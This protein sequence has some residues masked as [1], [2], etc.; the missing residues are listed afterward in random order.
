MY[1]M[2]TTYLQTTNKQ[3]GFIFTPILLNIQ[4]HISSNIKTRDTIIC[5]PAVRQ[6]F[7]PV[8]NGL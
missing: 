1:R 3:N 4:I 7:D 2:S 6:T 8:S 5:D